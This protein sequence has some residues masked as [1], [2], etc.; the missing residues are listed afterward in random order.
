[1]TDIEGATRAHLDAL[2]VTGGLHVRE[3]GPLT[4]S[5]LAAFFAGKDT[6]VR[7]GIGMLSW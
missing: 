4:Q 2:F 6:T 3:I 5:S 7:A 1:M